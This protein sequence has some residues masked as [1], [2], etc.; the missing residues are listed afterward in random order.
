MVPTAPPVSRRGTPYRGRSGQWAFLAHRISGFL[1][2][3]FLL[4]HVVDVGLV[5]SPRLYNEVHRVYGNVLLRAFEVGL[6]FALLYHSLN[7]IRIV[8]VDL[9]PGAVANERRLLAAV[10]AL[11]AVAGVPGAWVI[12]QPALSGRL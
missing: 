10:V 8:L 2:F 5:R 9:F 1:V 7:G 6:L 11:T 4:L 12:M 3:F